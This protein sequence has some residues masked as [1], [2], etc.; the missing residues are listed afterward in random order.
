MLQLK[1]LRVNRKTN[2]VGCRFPLIFGDSSVLKK[3]VLS[4]LIDIWFLQSYYKSKGI[5]QL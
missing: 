3:V 5:Y 1:S 2:V 4:D